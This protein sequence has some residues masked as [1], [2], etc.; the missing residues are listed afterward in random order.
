MVIDDAN[1][2]DLPSHTRQYIVDCEHTKP[3]MHDAGQQKWT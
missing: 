3:H 2:A 1:K